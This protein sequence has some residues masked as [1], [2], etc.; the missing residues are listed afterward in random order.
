MMCMTK[1][2]RATTVSVIFYSDPIHIWHGMYSESA[3][4]ACIQLSNLMNHE[5][6]L[7]LQ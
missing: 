6:Q 5:Y 7:L 2:K 4:V 3:P 1:T